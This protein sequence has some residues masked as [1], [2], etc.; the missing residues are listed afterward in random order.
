MSYSACQIGSSVSYWFQSS[1]LLELP[2]RASTA[3]ADVGMAA[4]QAAINSSADSDAL[5][6]CF[7]L[8]FA[9]DIKEPPPHGAAEVGP[10]HPPD[11]Q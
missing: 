2:P 3:D 6:G 8:R 10:A 9:E 11:G 5:F 1:R 7:R 4:Q